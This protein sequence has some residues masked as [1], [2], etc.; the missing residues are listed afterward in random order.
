MTYLWRVNSEGQNK[1]K[2]C[3]IKISVES[4]LLNYKQLKFT[5]DE[6]KQE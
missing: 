4:Y 2:N 1:H 5:L 3:Y 6:A